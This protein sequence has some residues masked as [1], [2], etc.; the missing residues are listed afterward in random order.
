MKKTGGGGGY[1][2]GL[3][4]IL[5]SSKTKSIESKSFWELPSTALAAEL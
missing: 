4:K 3:R 2:I 5:Y 1:P